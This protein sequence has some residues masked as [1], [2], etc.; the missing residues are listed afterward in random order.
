MLAGWAEAWA[1]GRPASAKLS[2]LEPLLAGRIIG[3]SAG[4]IVGAHLAAHGSVTAMVA[5]QQE[6]LGVDAPPAPEMARFMAALFKAKLFSRGVDGL[7]R[8]MGKSARRAAVAGEQEFAAAIARSYAPPDPWPAERE[9]LVTVVDAETGEFH[10]WGAGSGVPLPLAIA[11]SCAMPCAFPLVHVDG[12]VY[13]DGGIGSSTNAAVAAGCARVLVLDP[14]G[15]MLG[16]ASTLDAERRAL[17]AAGSRT[18]ALLPDEAVAKAMGMRVMDASRRAEVA[19][20][21]RAQGLTTAAGVWS[22]LH[23]AG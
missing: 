9:L 7:R 1:Q 22:F 10:A 17:E 4:A 3:T 19:V 23:R 8:S 13:M 11:A 12:R 2:P 21:S 14:L 16:S 6:P 20:R 15:R 5:E 18:L